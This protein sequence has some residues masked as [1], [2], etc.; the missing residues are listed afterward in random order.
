MTKTSF[1]ANPLAV[2]D[3]HRRH[4]AITVPLRYLSSADAGWEGLDAEA[5]LEPQE[6]EGWLTPILPA[7]S[8]V[9][10]RGGS[11]RIEARS[12]NGTWSSASMHAGGASLRAA[13]GRP[14]EGRWRTGVATPTSTLHIPCMCIKGRKRHLL[15]DTLGLR[16]A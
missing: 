12:A 4:G 6:L 7:V 14:Y 5:F 11:M 1:V 2:Q 16:I 15:V 13:W 3:A 9:F 8:L 10:F